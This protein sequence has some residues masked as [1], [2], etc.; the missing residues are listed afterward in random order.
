MS[1]NHIVV[2]NSASN[3]PDKGLICA[4][5]EGR[6]PPSDI[7]TSEVHSYPTITEALR[8][9]NSGQADFVYG[10]ASRMELDIQHYH[11]SNLVPVTLVNDRSNISFA[12]GKP[13]DINLLTILNKAIN[14]VSTQ[15]KDAILDRNLVSIGLENFSLTELIYANPVAFIAILT[16]FLLTLVVLLLGVYRA[17][18]RAVVI[19]SNLEKEEAESRAKG[20][21]LS[22]MSHE[23]RTPMNAVVGLTDLISMMKG[24]PADLQENLTKLRASAHYML[25]L[26][27]DILDMSRINSGKL[28]IA[29]EPFS[30]KRMLDE[31]QVMMEPEAKRRSLTYTQEFQITHSGLLGDGIRLRQVITNL[32]SNAF[33]FTNTG[34]WVLLRVTEE[35]VTDTH[36]TFTFQV[37]DN[38]VGI[39]EEDQARIFESFEQ[40]GMST[41][42]SQ[43]TGLGLPISSSI[44]EKMG[45]VLRV[46]SQPNQGSEF[47]F[48]ITLPLGKVVENLV[49]TDDQTENTLEGVSILL[50]E[51]NDLNAEI[52]IQLL[53][54]E[55]AKVCRTTN[56]RETLEQFAKSRQGEFQVILM[57][58]QMPEMNGLEAARAI[59]ALE[60]TDAAAIPIVAMTANTFQ[61]DVDAAKMA[62][63]NGFVPKPLNVNYLFHLLRDLLREGISV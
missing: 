18:M 56:G 24:V 22:H 55:G 27:N 62:G 41:T 63:M 16:L 20:E 28:T 35:A 17:R 60:R 19:Q 46:K 23:L 38:G 42:K 7:A 48:T 21:F 37:I 12:L 5:I 13:A 2:R 29:S 39:T 61:E 32:L 31:I 8:A 34:G 26:I 11:F 49:D 1:I 54:L 30:L 33:K 53:E 57:D 40:V 3:Y 52:A 44:V 47:F 59:R 43:G 4:T 50:A 15:S 9:V 58:I 45:G 36:A 10:L 14:S 51:D 25:D 6:I